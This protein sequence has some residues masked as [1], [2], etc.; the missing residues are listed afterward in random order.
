MWGPMGRRCSETHQTTLG[1]VRKLVS[2][3]PGAAAGPVRHAPTSGRP[4][5]ASSLTA[6]PCAVPIRLLSATTARL[7]GIMPP[8]VGMW[9]RP[10]RLGV[11]QL[12]GPMLERLAWGG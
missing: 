1:L 11:G 2:A 9:L 6:R 7:S 3:L 4:G 8:P 12:R 5:S 10:R